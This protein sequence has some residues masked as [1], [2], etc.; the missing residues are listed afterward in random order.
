MYIS[1]SL[2]YEH[3]RVF[4]KLAADRRIFDARC[5][6]RDYSTDLMNSQMHPARSHRDSEL[7]IND[8]RRDDFAAI[9]LTTKSISAIIIN[10]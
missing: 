7:F 8:I 4:T 5:I 9:I 6:A 1:Q 10:E 2:I 3:L